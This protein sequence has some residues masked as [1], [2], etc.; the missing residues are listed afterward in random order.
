[1]IG[2][3]RLTTKDNEQNL[4]KLY[5]SI[6]VTQDQQTV[7][8]RADLSSDLT[9]ELLEKVAQLRMRAGEVF[10]NQQ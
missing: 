1:G 6:D 7:H 9:D 4:L 10:P 3:A 5:D 2:L 8:V